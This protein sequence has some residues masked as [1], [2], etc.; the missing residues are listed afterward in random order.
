M[1]V[2]YLVSH[3]PSVT[4]TFI[5]REVHALRRLGVNVD[6]L[7]IHRAQPEELLSADDRQ[8]H[9]R[10]Y[11]VL[12]IRSSVLLRTH[13]LALLC[14]PRRYLA[15]LAFAVN[16]ANAGLRGRLW[17]LFY[18]AEAIVVWRAARSLG[19]RHLHAVRADVASD[20]ALLVTRYGGAGWSWSFGVHGPADFVNFDLSHV[21]EKAD[22]ARFVTAISDFAR[23]QVMTVT[24]EKCW[25]DI[26][27]VRC[28]V[29][30]ESFPAP[31]AQPGSDPPHIVCVG[32]LEQRKGQ[33]LL[34]EAFAELHRRGLAGRLTL[35]GDG[36]DRG[37]LEQLTRGHG[38]ADR[39]TFAGAVGQDRIHAIYRA[40]DIC[41]LPSMADAH[42]AHGGNGPRGSCCVDADYGR[43]RAGRRRAH[44]PAGTSRTC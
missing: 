9:D 23:S 22:A 6:T 20:V 37:H 38:L 33:A 32:R 19:V 44:R 13:L 36:P 41:C 11:A 1:Q 8:E 10:T 17:G 7:S 29:D 4:N 12:P 25:K 3:Y 18:F 40:A 39:V 21:A 15:T 35:V 14:S 43:P 42:R 30:P 24:P 31:D 16:R 34:V 2:G 26:H 27:V 28:G 5:T